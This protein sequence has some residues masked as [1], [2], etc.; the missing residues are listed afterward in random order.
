MTERDEQLESQLRARP[1][2]GLSDEA[3]RRL[4]ADLASVTMDNALPSAA[5][6]GAVMDQ[7]LRSETHTQRQ[8]I[9]R[10]I[11][12][13]K[14]AAACAAA[15]ACVAA[16]AGTAIVAH[17]ISGAANSDLP[18]HRPNSPVVALG[19]SAN[20]K[21]VALKPGPSSTL[22]ETETLKRPFKEQ[23]AEAEVIVVATFVDSAPAKSNRLA[24][25]AETVM[26]FR[27][28]RVLK[29]KL[30]K[31]IISIQHPDAPVGAG[32]SEIAGKEWV[33][34]LSPEYMAGKHP[35]TG[36][37]TIKLEPEVRT[38]LSSKRGDR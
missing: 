5:L 35:Y 36:L 29:G 37:W 26:R 7:T 1:L 4:L 3:R 21:S 6:T 24:E 13:H 32:V 28:A 33:L 18:S 12:T 27:V 11:L 16:I 38:I 22:L 9:W 30:D 23:V 34:L 25:A 2:R 17:R 15:A 19:P 14:Y 31:K 8:T 20:S 10:T